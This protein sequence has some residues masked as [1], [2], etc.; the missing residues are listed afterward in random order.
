M[1]SAAGATNARKSEGAI[2]GGTARTATAVASSPKDML[3]GPGT[4]DAASEAD[5]EGAA[6]DV[7][8]WAEV[9]M[10]SFLQTFS[11]NICTTP[12]GRFA[13]PLRIPEFGTNNATGVSI[14]Q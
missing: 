9:G 3:E 10:P 7:E 14:A 1:L 13:V 11:R 6:E 12:S 5:V 4:V 8:A 2:H